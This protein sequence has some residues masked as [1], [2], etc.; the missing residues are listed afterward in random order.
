M[1]EFKTSNRFNTSAVNNEQLNAEELYNACN[2]DLRKVAPDL[3]NVH[4]CKYF[5][6]TTDNV[7]YLPAEY[8][9]LEILAPL[10]KHYTRVLQ[11]VKEEYKTYEMCR[12]AVTVNK[13]NFVHVPDKFK[14]GPMCDIALYGDSAHLIPLRYSDFPSWYLVGDKRRHFILTSWKA[15]MPLTDAELSDEDILDKVL[16]VSNGSL[17]AVPEHMRTSAL[18]SVSVLKYKNSLCNVPS[19]YITE[20]MVLTTLNM[21]HNRLYAVPVSFINSNVI[22]KLKKVAFDS[23]KEMLLEVIGNILYNAQPKHMTFEFAALRGKLSTYCSED[24][25]RVLF[26][27][28]LH[29][30]YHPDNN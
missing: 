18:Y 4:V 25:L 26:D 7:K 10:M 24:Q 20:A 1:P 3:L 16:T 28:I 23:V 8:A 22:L 5:I 27:D 9:T 17:T 30:V 29:T 13:S 19:E 6:R 12:Y 11:N 2:G 21:E 15:D 14:D